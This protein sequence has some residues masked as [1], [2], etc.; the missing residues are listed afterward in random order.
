MTR[1]HLTGHIRTRA[2]DTAGYAQ[3]YIRVASF[4]LGLLILQSEYAYT[5]DTWLWHYQIQL[6]GYGILELVLHAVILRAGCVEYDQWPFLWMVGFLPEQHRMC[7][8]SFDI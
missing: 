4:Y 8:L 3:V 6:S 2:R 5:P 7:M 1:V